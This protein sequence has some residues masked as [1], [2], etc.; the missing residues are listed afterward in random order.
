[1]FVTAWPLAPVHATLR[2]L[3]WGLAGVSAAVW[4]LAAVGG[5]WACRRALAPVS[6]MAEAAKR[7]TAEQLSERLP[8][9]APRD[10]LQGLAVAFNGLLTRLQDSF[11]RQRRF[12]GEASHQLRTPLAALLGQMEVALRRDRD[13][14]EY[15]RVLSL[16]M[17]QAGRMRDIVEVL[18]FLARAEAD[19]RLPGL[20]PVDLGRWLPE[21]LTATWADHPRFGDI[22]I[23]APAGAALVALARAPLLGQAVNNLVDNALKYSGPGSPVSVRLAREAGEVVVIVE[24]RGPGIVAEDVGRVFDPFFRA[25]E[26]RRRGVA[27]VGLGL[28]V[29]ARIVAAL[30]GR[31]GVE[32]RPGEGSRFLIRLPAVRASVT[33]KTVGI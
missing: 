20:E 10:E 4:L 21:H 3:A 19:A 18:L 30:G 29:T 28:A 6:R 1:V 2:A 11:E 15:Q 14:E 5:R 24:D 32:S 9:P 31:V 33:V 16:A 27:G 7:I 13:P 23:D 12:T 8:V 22:Q 26:A 17:A 25:S